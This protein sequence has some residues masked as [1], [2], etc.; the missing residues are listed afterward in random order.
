MDDSER[1]EFKCSKCG[2]CCRSIKYYEPAEHLDRG[3]GV[4]KYY[5]EKTKLCTIYD[6]RPDICKVDKMYRLFKDKMTWN[7]YIDF[8]YDSCEKLRELE[9]SEK[10][11]SIENT[12][13]K[14]EK[15]KVGVEV[16][17]DWYDNKIVIEDK[18]EEDYLFDDDEDFFGE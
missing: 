1:K 10:G 7:E 14:E 9:K 8:N 5:D 12:E 11:V 13:V 6:F 15:E 2:C 16:K 17:N 18:E 3:D 4:C